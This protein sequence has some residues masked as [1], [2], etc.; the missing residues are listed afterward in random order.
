MIRD[1]E[2]SN[3]GERIRPHLSGLFL[4]VYNYGRAENITIDN[5]FIH[6]VYGSLIKGEGIDH[7]DAGG[8]QAMMIR[9]FRDDNTDSIPS[10]FD[11]L[12]VENCLIKDSQ[13]NGIIM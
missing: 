2:I 10:W 7:P 4:E 5:L 11:G 3:R 13:R 8:G 1:L 12:T 9:N 6:D